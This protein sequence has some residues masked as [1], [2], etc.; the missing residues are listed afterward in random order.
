[1][2]DV[3]NALIEVLVFLVVLPAVV[4]P[5]LTR[6]AGDRAKR[7]GASP[8]MVRSLRGLI[9]IAWLG[10]AGFGLTVAFGPLP[11]TSALTFTAV[12][13]IAITLALQTTLQNIVASF[14]L[15]RRRFLR[16]NDVILFGGTKGTVVS[17]GFVTTVLRQDDGT[18]VF[19]SNSNLLAG[20]LINRTATDRL[21]GEY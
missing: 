10:V 18:L 5:A 21:A 16:V 17:L 6:W 11:F 1:M 3:T 20:P 8:S 13:T 7:A 4:G 2:M 12:G 19:V 14:L 9:S 15:H